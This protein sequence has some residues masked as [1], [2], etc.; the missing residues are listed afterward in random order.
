[1]LLS[2]LGRSILAKIYKKEIYLNIKNKFVRVLSFEE[3]EDF[4]WCIEIC[5][6]SVIH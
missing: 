2:L 5:G 3:C 6:N 1:M 4:K